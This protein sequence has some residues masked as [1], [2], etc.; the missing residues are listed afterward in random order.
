MKKWLDKLGGIF[1]I[2]IVAGVWIF[3]AIGWYYGFEGWGG[4]IA[5]WIVL[6]ASILIIIGIFSR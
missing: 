3:V 2:A 6:I 1:I 4:K 5:L